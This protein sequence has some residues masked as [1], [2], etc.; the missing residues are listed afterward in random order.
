MHAVAT[1]PE[2]TTTPTP[3][4]AT[5]VLCTLERGTIH[6]ALKAVL[7]TASADET[8]P[9]LCGVLVEIK[10][11]T[12]ARLATMRLVTTDG[13]RLTRLDVSLPT[14]S[15]PVDS[16]VMLPT[17]S[18]VSLLKALSPKK[19]N[20]NHPIE[21]ELIPGEPRQPSTVRFTNLIDGSSTAFRTTDPDYTF[22][23][24]DKVIPAKREQAENEGTNSIGLNARYL[25]DLAVVANFA[26][27][28]KH[29]GVRLTVAGD[30]DPVRV[31]M[32][33]GTAEAVV[34]IMPM[35]I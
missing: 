1:E 15:N 17:A 9:H 32:T 2:P 20:A 3:E 22:P 28:D 12:S 11:S 24:Y 5:G 34:V 18:V 33:N 23:P 10:A 14:D 4:P 6:G 31:D 16:S 35:R 7:A 26:S 27:S 8:R 21:L 13:H 19:A 29:G 30:R 25:A